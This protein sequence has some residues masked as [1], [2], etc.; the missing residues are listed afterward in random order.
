MSSEGAGV[1]TRKLKQ[2]LI[3]DTAIREKFRPRNPLW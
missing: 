2:H 1:M 3:E